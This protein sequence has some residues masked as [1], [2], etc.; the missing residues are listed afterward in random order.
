[1]SER[2][3]YPPEGVD[4]RARTFAGNFTIGA[5]GAVT[6]QTSGALS[7]C[8]VTKNAAAG[9]YLLTFFK[10]FKTFKSATANVEGPAT[11]ASGGP[12]TGESGAPMLRAATGVAAS[13]V[14]TVSIQLRRNDTLADADA[15][16]GTKV[17]WRIELSEA[18]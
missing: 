16:S 11:A 18:A 15:T 2:I 4:I 17:H 13:G 3:L 6:A 14:S 9:R 10:S 8:V 5:A 7:G 12:T 1:M